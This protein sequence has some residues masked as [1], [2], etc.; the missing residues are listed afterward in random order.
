MVDDARES[1]IQPAKSAKRARTWEHLAAKRQRPSEYEIVSTNL[2]WRNINSESPF[3]LNPNI[4][5]SRWYLKYCNGSPLKHDNWE[6]FRDPDRLVYR[7]YNIMQDT[8]EAYVDGLLDEHDRLGHDTRLSNQWLSTLARMYAP[9]RYLMHT[10]QMASAYLVHM[11]P[12]STITVCAAFQMADS[13]RWVS[14]IAYRTQELAK[15]HPDKGFGKK[16]RGFWED[17]P[18]WQGFRELMEKVLVAYDWA[19]TVVALNAVAK[20]A[21]DEGFIRQLGAAAQ[22]NGDMLLKMLSDAQLRDSERSRR[23]TAELIRFALQ[24]DDNRQVLDRWMRKWAPLAD[25]ATAAFCGGL[26]E[27]AGAA[28]AAKRGAMAFRESL[29]L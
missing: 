24:K 2:N 28:E 7:T 20:P 13:L 22:A 26:P 6:D 10:V 18:A 23:W 21:I 1:K 3:E 17:D 19:E 25:K 15:H 11:A 27:A 8:E 29:G 5:M 4:P 9:G 12:A 14:R 16:E